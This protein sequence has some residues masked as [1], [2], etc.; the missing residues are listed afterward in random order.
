MKTDQETQVLPM[1]RPS[2]PDERL[3]YR[4]ELWDTENREAVERVLA[5]AANASLA[6]AIFKAAQD[7]HPDR[8][9]TVGRGARI[10]ADSVG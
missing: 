7:E 1:A 6:R 8:R 10:V 9:I 5:R 2:E 3:P 4:V